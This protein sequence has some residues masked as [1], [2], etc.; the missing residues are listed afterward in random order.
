M[1]KPPYEC[2]TRIDRTLDRVQVAPDDCGIGRDA[3]QRV[4]QGDDRPPACLEPR[5]DAGPAGGIRPGAMDEDDRGSFGHL[6]A[7]HPAS[8][9]SRRDPAADRRSVARIER[10]TTLRFDAIRIRSGTLLARRLPGTCP[11]A[12]RGSESRGVPTDGNQVGMLVTDGRLEELGRPVVER[13][14]VPYLPCAGGRS[15]GC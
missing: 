9:W 11:G 6:G 4:R 13:G 7:P 2:P 3:A 1:T 5:D 12:D 14:G 15:R 8:G 10:P